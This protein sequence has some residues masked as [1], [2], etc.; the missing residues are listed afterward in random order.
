MLG[1]LAH[2]KFGLDQ[3]GVWRALIDDVA[4][5]V[6]SYDLRRGPWFGLA[7]FDN[8]LF[9]FHLLCVVLSDRFFGPENR[10]VLDHLLLFGF[11][12]VQDPDTKTI[13]RK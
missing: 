13:K 12:H 6:R 10:L 2:V 9:K 8:P 11:N 1:R 7:F 3:L 5:Q 4:H